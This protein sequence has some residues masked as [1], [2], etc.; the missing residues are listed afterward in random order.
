MR[1]Q[2]TCSTCCLPH[3]TRKPALPSARFKDKPM[4]W[5]SGTFMPFGGGPRLCI[6]AAF[7]FGQAEIMLAALLS[8]FRI[9]LIDTEPVLP[10]GRGFLMPSYEPRCRLERI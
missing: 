2:S 6:G 9:S 4:P 10:V 3:V 1:R 7:A 8:R 5:T